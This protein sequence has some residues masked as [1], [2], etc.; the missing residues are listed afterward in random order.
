MTNNLSDD[1]KCKEE[2]EQKISEV[3]EGKVDKNSIGKG[4]FFSLNGTCTLR[5]LWL[6]LIIF[7]FGYFLYIVTYELYSS[8]KIYE[9]NFVEY[10]IV[11]VFAIVMGIWN[12]HLCCLFVQRTRATGYNPWLLIIPIVRTVI[13]LNMVIQPSNKDQSENMYIDKEISHERVFKIL[14]LISSVIYFLIFFF[15][16]TEELG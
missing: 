4:G 11:V 10:F 13:R 6:N 5:R 15:A 14:F 2:F 9:S 7:I 8:L 12:Y 1:Y 3:I 16:F